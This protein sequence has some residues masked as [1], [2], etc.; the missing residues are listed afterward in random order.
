VNHFQGRVSCPYGQLDPATSMRPATARDRCRVPGSSGELCADAAGN[1]A[2]C[3]TGATNVDEI[4]VPVDPQ[5]VFRAAQDTV[6]CSCRCNG[7]DPG[8]RYCECPSGFE[9]KELVREIG[10]EGRGQLVGDYCIKPG[11]MYDPTHPPDPQ[12]CTIADGDA[13]KELR[14]GNKKRKAGT[15]C[16]QT[17]SAVCDDAMVDKPCASNPPI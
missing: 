11:T 7:P 3:N 8:A 1:V 12:F 5:L 17:S 14:A 4:R 9:C 15:I 16:G 13:N 2:D 10:V 6:Y